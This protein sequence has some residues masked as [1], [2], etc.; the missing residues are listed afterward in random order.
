MKTLNP[1]N[2]KKLLVVFRTVL[3]IAGGVRAKLFSP[4]GRKEGVK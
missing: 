1:K 3:S 4:T 2:A